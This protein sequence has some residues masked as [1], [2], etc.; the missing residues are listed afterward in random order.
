MAKINIA[1][2]SGCTELFLK[3]ENGAPR[4]LDYEYDS[5]EIHK[6]CGGRQYY[7]SRSGMSGDGWIE[8]YQTLIPVGYYR[9]DVK[10]F[11]WINMREVAD[12]ISVM[13][14]Y[15]SHTQEKR[16]WAYPVVVT[17][18]VE[19]YD[20]RRDVIVYTTLEKL[21]KVVK[22]LHL[23][24][25]DELGE[26]REYA[27][28]FVDEQGH[29]SEVSFKF[30]NMWGDRSFNPWN[31]MTCK[32][33]KFICDEWEGVWGVFGLTRVGEDSYCRK[34]WFAGQHYRGEQLE[35]LTDDAFYEGGEA[36]AAFVPDWEIV[37]GTAA[38]KSTRNGQGYRVVIWRN[39]ENYRETY[40]PKILFDTAAS[41]EEVG[42]LLGIV[43]NPEADTAETLETE[44][45]PE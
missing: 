3:Y 32:L 15:Q 11:D 36:L 1:F 43:E 35:G 34:Y 18:I 16:W 44:E 14:P 37:D 9:T 25:E 10:N 42:T 4:V 2:G 30:I 17:R 24:N 40:A 33:Q 7:T 13:L 5:V 29:T 27:K 41:I 20:E 38:R 26:V 23:G 21:A 8:S 45:A 12:G 28:K 39:P 31:F 19:F 22:A 6:L